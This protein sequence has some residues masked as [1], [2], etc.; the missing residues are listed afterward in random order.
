MDGSLRAPDRG[1]RWTQLALTRTQLAALCRV[2][3][4]QVSYW[5]RQGYIM[6]ASERDDRYNG[7]AVD[8]CVLIRQ[9]LRAGVPLHRAVPLAGVHCGGTGRSARP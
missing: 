8:L 1:A 6:P 7:D 5:A 2:S 3:V 4:R 9:A